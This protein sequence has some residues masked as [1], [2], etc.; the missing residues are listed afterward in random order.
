MSAR[1]QILAKIRAAAWQAAA[2]LGANEASRLLAEVKSEIDQS[3][4]SKPG[5][6]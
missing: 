5:D 6:R 2:E 4:W 1:D 3:Q